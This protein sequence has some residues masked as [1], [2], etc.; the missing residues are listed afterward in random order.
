MTTLRVSVDGRPL[1][2]DY[3]RTQGIGRYAQGLL[4]ELPEVARERGGEVV[5]RRERP[6]APSPF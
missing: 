5:V 1:D 4:S 2:I 6:G 3:L